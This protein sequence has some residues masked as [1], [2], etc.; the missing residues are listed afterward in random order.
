VLGAYGQPLGSL[1]DAVALIGPVPASRRD[2]AC[3]MRAGLRWHERWL[4]AES[5]RASRAVPTAS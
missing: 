5:V 2:S 3:S 1:D 4:P